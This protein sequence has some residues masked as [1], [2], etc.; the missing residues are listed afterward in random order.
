[1]KAGVSADFD[2]P[3]CISSQWLTVR[4]E[5]KELKESITEAKFS[6]ITERRLFL[7]QI[8][9]FLPHPPPKSEAV[10]TTM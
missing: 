5:E 4:Y 9:T 6:Q 7:K 10:K 2:L 1:M 3:I 8:N